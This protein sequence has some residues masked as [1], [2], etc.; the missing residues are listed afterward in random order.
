MGTRLEEPQPPTMRP[1]R[2]TID[3]LGSRGEGIAAHEGRRVYV[4]YALPG[5]MVTADLGGGERATLIGLVTQSP[6]RTEEICPYFATC[7]GCAVQTLATPAYAA[8]KRGLVVDALSR[9]GVAAEVAPLVD[10]HGAGRRR[11]TFHSRTE[12]SGVTH[13]GFMRA[14]AHEIVDIEVCPVLDPRLEGALAAARAVALALPGK[15]LDL[16]VT[17]TEAGLDMDLRGHGAL[18]EAARTRLVAVALAHDLARLSN[19]G[20]IVLESRRPTVAFGAARVELPPGAF[21]Q[22]TEAG[23]GTLAALVVAALGDARRVADLFAGLGT[24]ALRLAAHAD[25]TA[26]DTEG[27]GLAALA[28]AAKAT[29]GLRPV[30]AETRD[31]FRRPLDRTALEAFDA[32]I[33]DPPR[34]GAEAQMRA[35]AG[36]SL[37]RVVSVACDVESF[38]RDAAILIAGGFE[39]GTVMP[40]DQ[41]RYSPHLEIVAVFHRRPARKVRRLLG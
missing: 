21:L 1:A 17:A 2:L 9:A 35:I 39:I 5:E 41:F 37:R 18:D 6:D 11:A 32:L 26:Y 29:P 14:R 30:T 20:V 25:V 10:A 28:R 12:P 22:A 19:H 27:L 16:V 4:P 3:R 24:F 40:I 23:E 15:P 31:L 38:A 33:L 36:S 8:W 34:A 13:V 7:G